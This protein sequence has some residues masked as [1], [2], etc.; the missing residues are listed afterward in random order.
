MP[1]DHRVTAT[2]STVELAREA[3]A[4]LEHRGIEAA[5]ISL[6]GVAARETKSD[7]ETQAADAR[8]TGH[9]GKR[10]LIGAVTG[11]AAGLVVA[12]VAAGAA[13]I[14]VVSGVVAGAGVGGVIGGIWG[15]GMSPAWERTFQ[16]SEERPASV[17]VHGDDAEL[18]E[19][20]AAV[21]Q[22]HH[23]VELRRS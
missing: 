19:R 9:V 7:R 23:P 14:A 8:L 21:L 3:I 15:L 1:T 16:T 20:A 4:A 13:S 17:A 5:N 12:L 6:L 18:V 10:I 2:F 11:A 22:E